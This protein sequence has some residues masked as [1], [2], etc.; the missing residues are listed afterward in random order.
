MVML[1]MALGLP[2]Q[3]A[4]GDPR[5]Q[6]I[7]TT[8]SELIG[9]LRDDHPDVR[10]AAQRKLV[11]LGHAAIPFLQSHSGSP[12]VEIRGQI[13]DAIRKIRFMD[14]LYLVR[15][16]D[17]RVTLDL[18]GVPLLAAH[19]AVFKDFPMHPVLDRGAMKQGRQAI[20]LK[21]DRATYW[22]A[23]QAFAAA[24]GVLFDP[25]WEQ[26]SDVD[27]KPRTYSR[28]N[29]P[30]L[31]SAESKWE[32]DELRLGIHLHLDGGWQPVSTDFAFKSIDTATGESLLET[33]ARP[34]PPLSHG[35]DAE[36]KAKAAGL[37]KGARLSVRGS[38][39][40]TLPT[41]VEAVEFRAAGFQGPQERTLGHCR[42]TL[43]RLEVRG[44]KNLSFDLLSVGRIVA[45]PPADKSFLAETWW[46]IADDEGHSVNPMRQ[47]VYEKGESKG[48][49]LGF[50]K[51]P[52]PTRLVLLRPLEVEQ[53]ELRLEIDGIVTPPRD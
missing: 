8:V 50:S 53:Q 37:K 44:D 49:Q 24:A 21:L 43:S 27:T 23:V 4:P 38:V 2:F 30:F 45:E 7:E 31:F 20:T 14:P 22:E 17:R 15:A 32:G 16:P 33:F 11:A 19:E 3:T 29:G 13:A 42:F 35:I 12:E 40:A 47:V 26:F 28:P 1:L 9:H 34:E 52:T 18:K 6:D 36:L 46:F 25:T 51:G 10:E 41:R 48:T 39:R 5:S